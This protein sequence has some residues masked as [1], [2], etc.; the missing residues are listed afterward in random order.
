M[1]SRVIKKLGYE[2]KVTSPKEMTVRFMGNLAPRMIILDY[3]DAE[4]VMNMLWPNPRAEEDIPVI[5][6][7]DEDVKD[8]NFN[9]IKK[10]MVSGTVY[11]NKFHE[12]ISKIMQNAKISWE[13]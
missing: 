9:H 3:V 11:K 7:C 1:A 13:A 4:K 2:C 6:Y 5:I 8:I 12:E 10:H